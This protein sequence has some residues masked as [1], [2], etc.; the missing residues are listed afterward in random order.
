MDLYRSLLT[1]CRP[2]IEENPPS[3]DSR[4]AQSTA[5]LTILWRGQSVR[6]HGEPFKAQLPFF[7]NSSLQL[8]EAYPWTKG[9]TLRGIR[10]QHH[11]T[12]G[13]FENPVTAP[14]FRIR[15]RGWN[16]MYKWQEKTGQTSSSM[17]CNQAGCPHHP[18][19]VSQWEII[20]TYHSSTPKTNELKEIWVPNYQTSLSYTVWNVLTLTVS[21]TSLEET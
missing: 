20:Y 18:H 2:T 9:R 21:G 16:N 19:T 3:C 4:L 7:P 12:R 5:V 6:R 15:W 1:W 13:M 10:G 17:N 14:R 8:K 11:V